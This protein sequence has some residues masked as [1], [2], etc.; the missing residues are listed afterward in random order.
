MTDFAIDRPASSVPRWRAYWYLAKYRVD[1]HLGLAIAWSLVPARVAFQ[2][3]TLAIV[4]L[5]FVFCATISS[6]AIVFDDINGF[7]D[8]SDAVNYPA[9]DPTGYRP[10]TKKPLVAD[11]LT[12]REAIRVGY[13]LAIISVVSVVLAWLIAGRGG[14]WWLLPALI[15]ASVCAAQYSFGLKFSYL[16]A[17]DIVLFTSFFCTVVLPFTLMMGSVSG[18]ALLMGSLL[19]LWDV[20]VVQFSNIPDI[21]A[22]RSVGR[23]TMA[24]LLSERGHTRLILATF[25]LIW[26]GSLGGIVSGY[27][28]PIA[29]LTLIP[30]LLMHLKQLRVGFRPGGAMEGRI[31]GWLAMRA[32]AMGVVAANLLKA[33]IA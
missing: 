7:R 30:A 20:Q 15:G 12:E 31:R 9:H 11:L 6:T 33:V 3:D 26:A 25:A 5:A 21:E 8:G 24:V 14:G 19:G 32:W 1:I 16:G 10:R 27:L 13:T 29:L 17:Q 23:R 28:P 2:H 22:D 4:A 18:P